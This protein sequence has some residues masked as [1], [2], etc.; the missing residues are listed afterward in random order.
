MLAE[1]ARLVADRQAR[2]DRIAALD[3]KSTADWPAGQAAVKAAAT[4]VREA[5][6]LLRAA[7][8][9][10]TAA[11]AAAFGASAE[12]TRARQT[13]ERALIAGA[14]TGVIEAW[15]RELR[16]ELDA[17]RRPGVLFSGELISRDPV[18]RKEIK[19]SYS[20]RASIN[21]RL[22]AVLETLRA[23]DLLKLEADQSR[24]PLIIAA[25]RAALP[26]VDQNP[27]IVETRQ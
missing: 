13:E 12:Y 1:R 14:D 11:N 18:S 24:L 6:R 7:N 22:A 20:N 10:L 3:A 2:V 21:K 27:S 17:L 26:K 8:D 15:Q 25:L 19:S 5:E 4:K 23:S 16:D 9:A